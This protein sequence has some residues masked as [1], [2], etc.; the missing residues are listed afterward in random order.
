LGNEEWAS[1]ACAAAGEHAKRDKHPAGAEIFYKFGVSHAFRATS[2]VGGQAWCILHAATPGNGG[3]RNERQARLPEYAS[4]HTDNEIGRYE[5]N[6]TAAL[7][8]DPAPEQPACAGTGRARREP[9]RRR[10]PWART[11]AR[12]P[13]AREG[14]RGGSGSATTR[15]W[16]ESMRM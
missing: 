13:A 12:S 4:S 14:A 7:A 5:A 8:R 3:R 9:L 10:S 15:G 11:R 6:P 1:P 16:M 2:P